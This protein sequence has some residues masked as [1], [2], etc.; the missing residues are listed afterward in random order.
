M[1]ISNIKRDTVNQ[2]YAEVIFFRK[3][4]LR[5]LPPTKCI[6]CIGLQSGVRV[7]PG[8]CE[9]ILGVRETSYI[10]HNETQEPLES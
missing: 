6:E 10:T 5:P 3:C 4:D 7:H 9:G 2:A 8:V 1:Q